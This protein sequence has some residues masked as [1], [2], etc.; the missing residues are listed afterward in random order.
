MFSGRITNAIAA[1]LR[2]LLT[3]GQNAKLSAPLKQEVIDLE[4]T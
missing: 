1:M 3:F 2:L 4:S